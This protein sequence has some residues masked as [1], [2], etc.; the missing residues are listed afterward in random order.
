M[1]VGQIDK[2]RSL[3]STL[4]PD[5]NVYLGFRL[6]MLLPMCHSSI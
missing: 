1:V 6:M 2:I 5:L 3:Y 4:I